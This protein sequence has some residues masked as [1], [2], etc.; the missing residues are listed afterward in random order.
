MVIANAGVGGAKHA[1][2]TTLDEVTRMMDVNVRGAMATLLGAVPIMVAA[3]RGQLVGVSSIAGRRALPGGAAYSASKAALS[4]FLEG[5]RLDL[6][7]M[8]IG[9]SDVQPGFVDTPMTQKND[10]EMPF[11]WEAGYA[12][13]FIAGRLEGDPRIVAFPWQLRL[14]SWVGKR[15]PF[16]LYA[17]VVRRAR[18]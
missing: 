2:R 3:Q 14:A 13:R 15:L 16:P 5:L 8:G 12:A 1:A 11:M 18:R 7:P 6:A 17:A 9:V 10:F 4:V